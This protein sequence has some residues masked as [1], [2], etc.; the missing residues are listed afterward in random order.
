MKYLL[1][2]LFCGLLTVGYAQSDNKNAGNIELKKE[3]YEGKVVTYYPGTKQIM[4]VG[5]YKNGKKDGQWVRYNM[6]GVKINE[7]YFENGMPTGK[8][9]V[10]DDNG[11]KRFEM[12]YK[13]GKKTG[14]WYMW[15]ENANLVSER[16]Y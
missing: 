6:K 3:N 5:Y 12:Q 14:T 4:E 13:N 10:W 2:L 11:V 8:W 16:T 9:I 1:S 7:A 15:D